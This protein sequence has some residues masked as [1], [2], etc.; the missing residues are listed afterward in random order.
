[1]KYFIFVVHGICIGSN[2]E[3]FFEI[4][5]LQSLVQVSPVGFLAATLTATASAALA[6]T[7]YKF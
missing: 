1:M 7:F 3:F 6:V 4:G 5:V 2:S